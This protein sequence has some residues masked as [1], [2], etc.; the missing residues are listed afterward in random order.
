MRCSDIIKQLEQLAPIAYAEN[1]DN[2][3]LL[4]G[5][6]DKEIKKI[7]IA[8][9][10][11]AEVIG[12]AA[13][14]Q[15]DLLLTH[16]PLI[17][18]PLKCVNDGDFIGSRVLKLI[19]DDISYYA[20]HTNYDIAPGCMA[21][22]AAERLG[23]IHGRVLEPKVET[24]GGWYGVGK[25]GNL[26]QPVT[27]EELATQVKESFGLPFVRIYS[28]GKSKKLNLAAIAP[29]SG[30]D[31]IPYALKQGAEVLIT[32]DI[33]HHHG[34]DAVARDMA[35]IDAG[36]YGLEH[37]FMEHMETYIGKEFGGAVKVTKAAVAF[38]AMIW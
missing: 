13:A 24:D 25:I 3:G 31:S 33:G 15:A 32:G 18:K 7:F 21:D 6:Y 14:E 1:W 2:V 20:M 35:V 22:L 5:R 9:D 27:V 23:L 11:T 38:P 26:R 8:L 10:A 28:D 4:T 30:S 29:G 17:F 16:H 12:L 37:I 19:Q 34:I 36:H